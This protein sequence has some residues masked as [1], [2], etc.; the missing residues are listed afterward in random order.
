[1]MCSIYSYLELNIYTKQSYEN[2]V[3]ANTYFNEYR[4]HIVSILKSDMKSNINM[5][6]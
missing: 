6:E 2:E 1:M 5:G 4:Y 3:Y